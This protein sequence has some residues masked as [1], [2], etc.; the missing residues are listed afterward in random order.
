MRIIAQLINR[1][2]M[3]Y[4]IIIGVFATAADWITFSISLKMFSIP[5]QGALILA[6]IIG[7]MVHYTANKTITF[8]CRSRDYGSQLPLYILLA[9]LNFLCSIGLMIVLVKYIAFNKIAARI[10]TTCFM[11]LPNYLLHKHIT[12]NKRIFIQP[13]IDTLSDVK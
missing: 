8:N 12:F 7:G 10:A 6:L 2:E 5:Y 13:D 9:F 11:I 4:Y 3:I 1:K